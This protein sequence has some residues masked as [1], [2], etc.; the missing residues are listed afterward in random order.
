LIDPTTEALCSK[1]G[2]Q[3]VAPA[4]KGRRA[5][6]CLECRVKAKASYSPEKSREYSQRW[7][8]KNPEYASQYYHAN[9]ERVLESSTQ[10]WRDN[11][12]R[13]R[14]RRYGLTLD[15]L[16]NLLDSQEGCCPICHRLLV[17]KGKGGAQIDHDP[18]TMAVRGILC[19]KCN[20][21]LGM[22][23][24]D[25]GALELAIKYLSQI[26][27]KSDL[28]GNRERLAEMTSPAAMCGE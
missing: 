27:T 11:M 9:R 12:L 6:R 22:F 17:L 24:E 15:A 4:T 7:R 16:R 25:I 28:T 26:K 14:A 8:S 10:W 2:L 19:R 13:S 21:G 5:T 20:V 3:P 18:V 1:C 23:D